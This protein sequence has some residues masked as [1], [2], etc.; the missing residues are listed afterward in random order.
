LRAVTISHAP[1]LAGTPSPEPA[2]RGDRERLL[3]GLLSE[4]EIAEETD[5]RGKHAPPLV[6]ENL[7]Q[8]R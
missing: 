2:L 7:F 5:Q 4:I 6:A 3:G 1:G 8:Q